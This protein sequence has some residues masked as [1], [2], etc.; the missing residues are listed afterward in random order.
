MK[1][2]WKTATFV[3]SLAM[4]V[5]SVACSS[6]SEPEPDTEGN[7]TESAPLREGTNGGTTGGTITN[8][9]APGV[10]AGGTVTT[11]PGT[12]NN[13]PGPF[14]V[15]EKNK[16]PAQ[17]PALARICDNGQAGVPECVKY[18]KKKSCEWTFVCGL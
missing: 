1:Y 7:T 14:T 5:T 13:G 6:A 3:V 15:C 17:I 2:S 11:G 8:P 9:I 16:C 18:S 4:A 10:P 12:S